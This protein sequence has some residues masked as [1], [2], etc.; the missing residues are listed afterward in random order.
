LRRCGA[1]RGAGRM[2]FQLAAQGHSFKG[3]MAY[4]LH[5]KRQ[6]GQDTPRQTAERVDWTETRNLPT[7][8]AHTAT[9]VMIATA[10][11]AD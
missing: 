3:A 4:Y 11:N 6:D 8:G 5:D 2:N 9:R 7:D 10:K 1:H